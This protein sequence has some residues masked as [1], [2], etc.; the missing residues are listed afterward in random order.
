MQKD[1]V[2]AF[3]NELRNY[4]YYLYRVTSLENSIE[5]LYDRLGGVKGVDPSKEPTHSQPN[6]EL[7]WKLRDDIS[8]LETKKRIVEAKILGIDEILDLIDDPLQ[9]AVKSVYI[10][11]EK[12][13][14]VASDLFLSS[15]GLQKRMNKAIEE[16][17]NEV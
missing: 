17:L 8:R 9:T 15:T 3:K 6:K 5:F 11:G 13:I 12:C 4:N 2:R 16:A 7:E 1:S 10:H 14:K